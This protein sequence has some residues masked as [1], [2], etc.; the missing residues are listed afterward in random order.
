LRAAHPRRS[1]SRARR[2]SWTTRP[3]LLIADPAA[4]TSFRRP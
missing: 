4:T 3:R 2:A 1:P